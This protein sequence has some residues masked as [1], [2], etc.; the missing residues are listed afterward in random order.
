[1]ISLRSDN[2]SR[3]AAPPDTLYDPTKRIQCGPARYSRTSH[4]AVL[5]PVHATAS[6]M[7]VRITSLLVLRQ[8]AENA[9]TEARPPQQSSHQDCQQEAPRRRYDVKLVEEATCEPVSAGRV[10]QCCSA[11]SCTSCCKSPHFPLIEAAMDA[12]THPRLLKDNTMTTVHHGAIITSG[13]C[14]TA[15]VCRLELSSHSQASRPHPSLRGASPRQTRPSSR[16][17]RCPA[18]HSTAGCC[19]RGACNVI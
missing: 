8:A 3:Q 16:L 18:G 14:S 11:A 10:G 12:L 1:V 6:E 4:S 15:V 9:P 2:F 19:V 7:Q 17:W 5:L 13:A